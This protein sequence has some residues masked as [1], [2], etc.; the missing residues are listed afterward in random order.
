MKFEIFDNGR[1]FFFELVIYKINLE[2]SSSRYLYENRLL[3][4][5]IDSKLDCFSIILSS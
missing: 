4:N 1:R 2:H 3:L 5:S